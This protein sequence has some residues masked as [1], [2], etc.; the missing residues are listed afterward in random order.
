MGDLRVK[1]QCRYIRRRAVTTQSLKPKPCKA[2]V[3]D[4]NA[5]LTIVASSVDRKRAI[6]IQ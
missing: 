2:T 6:Q 3:I 4:T 1:H 5:V